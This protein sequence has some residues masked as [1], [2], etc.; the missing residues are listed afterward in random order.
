M[1]DRPCN[2]FCELSQ[3]AGPTGRPHSI[4]SLVVQ[5]S[6]SDRH[7]KQHTSQ[8][9]LV[10]AGLLVGVQELCAAPAEDAR[11]PWAVAPVDRPIGGNYVGIVAWRLALRT[12][13]CPGG[14]E[15]RTTEE[16]R[17]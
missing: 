2:H 16:T 6:T 3:A 15:V 1:I 4:S 9:V 8:G 5:T 7:L 17:V 10:T 13:E 12:P 14:R 11:A